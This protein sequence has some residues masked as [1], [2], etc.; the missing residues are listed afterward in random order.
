M[1]YIAC[2]HVTDKPSA[3]PRYL[4]SL[5]YQLDNILS[6]YIHFIVTPDQIQLYTKSCDPEFL[7][8]RSKLL[9]YTEAA[10]VGFPPPAD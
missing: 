6:V 2:H 5:N 3:C 9:S 10:A 7:D 4:P 8:Q 1:K